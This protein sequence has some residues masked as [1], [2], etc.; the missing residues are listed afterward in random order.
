MLVIISKYLQILDVPY[1][2]GA[3]LT[4]TIT[5]WEFVK[6]LDFLYSDGAR[7]TKDHVSLSIAF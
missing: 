1:N 6:L 3:Q 2:D 5:C 7:R 4:V